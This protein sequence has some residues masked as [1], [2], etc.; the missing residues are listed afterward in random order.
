VASGSVNIT[1]VPGTVLGSK[2][3]LSRRLVENTDN[4]TAPGIPAV[5]RDTSA[6]T[7]GTYNNN[8][9]IESFL[10][11]LSIYI[12]LKNHRLDTVKIYMLHIHR[13]LPQALYFLHIT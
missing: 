11:V 9:H 5:R 2:N 1:A 3:P 12:A 13:K 6:A 4:T 8:H 7:I 10:H